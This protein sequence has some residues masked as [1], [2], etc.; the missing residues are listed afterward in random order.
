MCRNIFPT[1]EM[2]V[3]VQ[4]ITSQ[5][6]FAK[7][8]QTNEVIDLQEIFNEYWSSYKDQFIVLSQS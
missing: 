5:R 2:R 7:S 3:D 6:F 8:R 4:R 1:S